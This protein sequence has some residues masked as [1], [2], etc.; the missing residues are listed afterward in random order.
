MSTDFERRLR[1][2]RPPDVEP[3]D[4]TEARLMRAVVGPPRRRR[5]AEVW[6]RGLPRTRGGRL[7][8]I[9]ALVLGAATAAAIA[10]G[11]LDRGPQPPSASVAS[12]APPAW[13]PPVVLDGGIRRVPRPEIAM[14]NAGAALVAWSPGGS[15]RASYRPHGGAWGLPVRLSRSGV[16]TGDPSLAMGHDGRSAVVVWRERR[17][18]R[19]DR[20]VLRLPD[21][22]VAGVI[23]RRVGGRYV[24]V[25]R[26]WR[27][28]TGW[29][30]PTDVSPVGANQRD[31]ARPRA[32]ASGRDFLIAWTRGRGL[33]VRS[34]SSDGGLGPLETIQAGSGGE[35]HAP[36]LAASGPDRAVLT[37]AVRVSSPDPAGFTERTHAVEVA[38]RDGGGWTT[39]RIIAQGSYNNPR[40]AA[41]ITDGGSAAVVWVDHSAGR[42]SR[43]AASRNEPG[44]GWETP[45]MLSA[46]GRA[47]FGPNVAI[48]GAGRIVAHWSVGAATQ[49]AS[50]LGRGPWAA[51]QG[52]GD[53]GLVSEGM[54]AAPMLVEDGAGRL[55][56]A[57]G[58]RSGAVIRDWRPGGPFGP[59]SRPIVGTGWEYGVAALA[60]SPSG[61]A[62][63]A[64]TGFGLKGSWGKGW[65]VR[66]VV[67]ESPGDARE[68]DGN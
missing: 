58:K 8:G 43:I 41:A 6:R 36:Y 40:P 24:L 39:A 35:P 49:F 48:D 27:E 50:A 29:A 5:S 44:G 3:S 11:V 31:M 14:D 62:A 30:P 66:V 32:V 28:A 18:T 45:V 68:G 38:T 60:A 46:R 15:V 42:R 61:S 16:S 67:R 56:A 26:R 52:G 51:A 47:A 33:E 20:R 22:S 25:A 12:P 34:L 10:A 65:D 55:V 37:W 21:G 64:L 23:Q 4:Q 53:A 13:A 19:V 1:E 63:L 17:G 54:R 2:G 7:L 59:P 57:F 9:A